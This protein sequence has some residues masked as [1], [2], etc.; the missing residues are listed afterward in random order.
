MDGFEQDAVVQKSTR[1]RLV[2]CFNET[3]D[4]LRDTLASQ[5]TPHIVVIELVKTFFEVNEHQEFFQGLL[6]FIG[7]LL[8]DMERDNRVHTGSSAL[9]ISVAMR[10]TPGT[11]FDFML[12]VAV[13][14]SSTDGAS[15]LSRLMR[16]TL[17]K[18]GREVGGVVD[19]SL[20]H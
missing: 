9:S 19:T 13:S 5:G 2:L 8:D 12:R 3:D 10:S 14:I 11:L 16:R 4:F 18:P 15:V 20:P 6:E 1:E 17:D 7:L